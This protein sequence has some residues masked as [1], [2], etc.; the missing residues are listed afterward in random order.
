MLSP[1]CFHAFAFFLVVEYYGAS[2]N[3]V[4]SLLLSNEIRFCRC[5]TVDVLYN[6]RLT[7]IVT[8]FQTYLHSNEF[9]SPSFIS[10]REFVLHFAFSTVPVSYCMLLI[11]LFNKSS[12]VYLVFSSQLS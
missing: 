2:S 4:V 1:G 5:V 8:I 6:T 9:N 3:S 12:A 10:C 7:A 11:L